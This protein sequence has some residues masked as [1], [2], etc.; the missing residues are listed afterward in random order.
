M[1][2]NV[3]F[4]SETLFRKVISSTITLSTEQELDQI[5]IVSG[6]LGLGFILFDAAGTMAVC[7]DFNTGNTPRYTFTVASLSGKV[8]IV[9]TNEQY[10]NL[11][12]G[13]LFVD[14]RPGAQNG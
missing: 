3:G 9:T 10:Q 1:V 12:E 2:N 4:S 11:I 6:N 14:N 7:T 5:S 13:Q 8:T